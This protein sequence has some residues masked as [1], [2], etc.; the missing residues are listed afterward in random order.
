MTATLAL[1]ALVITVIASRYG[2][3]EARR[4]RALGAK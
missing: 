3:R 2:A 4:L 1:A